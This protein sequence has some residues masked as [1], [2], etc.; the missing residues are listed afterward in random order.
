MAPTDVANR[1]NSTVYRWFVTH[2]RDVK[3]TKVDKDNKKQSE[4]PHCYLCKANNKLDEWKEI[5]KLD[6]K[7][8]FLYVSKTC[9]CR[10]CLK[11]GHVI[12]HCKKE[13]RHLFMRVYLKE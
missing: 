1:Q 7:A 5:N 10:G 3:A 6:N 12:K 8:K 4:K 11:H 13:R 2:L 9:L